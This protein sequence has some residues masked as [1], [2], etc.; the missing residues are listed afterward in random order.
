MSRDDNQHGSMVSI[1]TSGLLNHQRSKGLLTGHGLIIDGA[2]AYRI[3]DK[4]VLLSRR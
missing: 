2:Y 4:L 3:G 1:R